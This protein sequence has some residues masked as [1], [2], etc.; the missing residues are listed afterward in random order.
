MAENDFA[1]KILKECYSIQTKSSVNA[2]GGG[3]AF[4][5][6]ARVTRRGEIAERLQVIVH[7]V[8]NLQ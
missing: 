6:A 4:F 3:H 5:C 7:R 8:T 1:F 2:V